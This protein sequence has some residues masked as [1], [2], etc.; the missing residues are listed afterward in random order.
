MKR[1]M[2]DWHKAS[3]CT[4]ACETDGGGL[5]KLTARPTCLSHSA[6][7]FILFIYFFFFGHQQEAHWAVKTG[8]QTRTQKVL[9][10]LYKL[11]RHPKKRGGGSSLFHHLVTGSRGSN[12]AI[13]TVCVNVDTDEAERRNHAVMFC[14]TH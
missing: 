4:S 3:E 1:E 8:R 6:S 13:S 2:G 10:C 5:R 14:G 11:R 9:Y 12:S 7:Q